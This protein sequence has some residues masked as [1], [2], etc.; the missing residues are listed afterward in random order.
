MLGHAGACSWG[1]LGQTDMNFV[2]KGYRRAWVQLVKEYFGLAIHAHHW[3]AEG[4]QPQ[5]REARGNALSPA[6]LCMW[7]SPMA[8]VV[9]CCWHPA[10]HRLVHRPPPPSQPNPCMRKQP[11][12]PHSTSCASPWPPHRSSAPSLRSE[13]WDP[14]LATHASCAFKRLAS[15]FTAL[16]H[17]DHA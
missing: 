1:L 17:T 7:R 6:L 8:S 11:T 14:V 13:H 16:S 15:R 2:V 5:V 3:P 10:C 12:P 9:L 4:G